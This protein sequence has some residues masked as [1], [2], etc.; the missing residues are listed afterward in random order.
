MVALT[1]NEKTTTAKIQIV[2]LFVFIFCTLCMGLQITHSPLWG[3]EIVEFFFSQ[4]SIITG[5]LFRAVRGTLQP[6]LFNVLMHFWLMINTSTLWFRCFNLLVGIITIIFIYKTVLLISDGKWFYSCIAILIHSS[7]YQYVYCVQEA[8]EYALMI[9]FCILA[10]YYFLRIEA[11][12][13][14]ADEIV[15]VLFCVCAMFCQYG[16][17][18]AIILFSVNCPFAKKINNGTAAKTKAT[19]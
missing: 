19:I 6:P 13:S 1:K 5:D 8:S 10:I 2:V 15:F 12:C 7:M 14:L 11:E 16:A 18:F 4:K 3:D 9:L 17:A